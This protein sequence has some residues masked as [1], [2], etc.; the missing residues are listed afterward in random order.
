[1]AKDND[2]GFSFD[3][4]PF[5]SGLKKVSGGIE[6]LAKETKKSAM[7]MG[8]SFLHAMVKMEL[9]KAAGRKI[10]GWTKELA[11]YMPEIGQSIGIMKEIIMKN[12]AWPLRK[13]IVPLLQ[14]MLNWVRDNR[15]TFVKWGMAIVSVFKIVAHVVKTAWSIL[16]M[17]IDIIRPSL[18]LIF[19]DTAKGLDDVFNML[20]LKVAFISQFILDLLGPV[21]EWIGGAVNDIFPK[22]VDAIGKIA[23]GF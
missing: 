16:K 14:K 5:L 19:G 23:E 4:Q 13:F 17:F 8:K 7:A 15:T 20:A 1:M 18:K 9:L 21:M 12:L 3:A 11:T 6:N 2:V 10:V 22:L